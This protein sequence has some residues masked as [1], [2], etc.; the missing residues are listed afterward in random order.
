MSDF[1]VNEMKVIHRYIRLN[2]VCGYA[3]LKFNFKVNNLNDTIIVYVY[4]RM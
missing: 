3:L 2:N 1:I 4:Y